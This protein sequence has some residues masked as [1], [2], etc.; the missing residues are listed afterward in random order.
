MRHLLAVVTPLR[1]RS[2]RRSSRFYDL[3]R[4]TFRGRRRGPSAGCGPVTITRTAC[5]ATR[6]SGAEDRRVLRWPTMAVEMEPEGVL[7]HLLSNDTHTEG[8][9]RADPSLWHVADAE[10]GG[11]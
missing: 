9:L 1:I 5:R 2:A 11:R 7:L 8:A 6:S 3:L 4:A 10:R